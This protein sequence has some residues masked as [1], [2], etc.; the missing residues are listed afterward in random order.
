MVSTGQ[1]IACLHW[2]DHDLPGGRWAHRTD[3]EVLSALGVATRPDAMYAVTSNGYVLRHKR[4]GIIPLTATDSAIHEEVIRRMG[5]GAV[6]PTMYWHVLVQEADPRGF[7]S[8]L[9][10][11]VADAE[12]S[13]TSGGPAIRYGIDTP[14]ARAV[15]LAGRPWAW[16]TALK[17][18]P[19][20][21]LAGMARD[22][23]ADMLRYNAS[24]KKF[25]ERAAEE[26]SRGATV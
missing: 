10:P 21:E 2:E 24:Q 26:A 13:L 20:A 8:V 18:A 3:W 14:T 16:V 11:V 25:R 9:G 19:S 23:R 22:V 15:A 17:F 7:V 12:S 1:R 4:A 5:S 6:R